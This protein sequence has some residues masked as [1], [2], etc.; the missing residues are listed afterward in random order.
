MGVAVPSGVTH[1]P[2][3]CERL[4]VSNEDDQS[5]RK[6]R[7]NRGGGALP[8]GKRGQ[9]RGPRAERTT[10]PG[11]GRRRKAARDEAAPDVAPTEVAAAR[12]D[13][14]EAR[15]AAARAARMERRAQSDRPVKGRRE[16]GAGAPAS[17]STN[18][19]IRF[20]SATEPS[21]SVCEPLAER[22]LAAAIDVA[23]TYFRQYVAATGTVTDEY[24]A[25]IAKTLAFTRQNAASNTFR[26]DEFVAL[27]VLVSLLEPQLV[28]VAGANADAVAAAYATSSAKVVAVGRKAD[29]LA[30]AIARDTFVK[31]DFGAHDFGLL[32]EGALAHIGDSV[33]TSRR[34]LEAE[35]K[36]FDA[37]V[38]TNSPGVTG[39]VRHGLSTVPTLPMIVHADRYRV[40]DQISWSNRRRRFEMTITEEMLDE[41]R[42]AQA[43]IDRVV[44]F[45]VL[46]DQI[47]LPLKDKALAPPSLVLFR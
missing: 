43:V 5:P 15:R 7:R 12:G 17:A 9:R 45:P 26:E 38:V 32:P 44:P 40:G 1:C 37:A 8:D 35:A 27:A 19:Y 16:A 41:M 46:E 21:F 20:A 34:L 22:L 47:A 2:W 10:G 11:E 4:H 28:A 3:C 33:P 6:R 14:Q 24:R 39:I 42:Q 18:P 13:G 30:R 29:K 23:E 31:G 25:A 36:G